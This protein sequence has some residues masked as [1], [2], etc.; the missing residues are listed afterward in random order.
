MS[1]PRRLVLL[2]VLTAALLAACGEA[3]HNAAPALRVEPAVGAPTTA[4]IAHAAARPAV[5]VRPGL[6]A[7]TEVAPPSAAPT[8]AGGH[9]IDAAAD[10]AAEVAAA[11]AERPVDPLIVAGEAADA[12]AARQAEAAA[13]LATARYAAA[14]R[15]D[16]TG[17]AVATAWSEPVYL[18][19]RDVPLILPG[20]PAPLPAFTPRAIDQAKLPSD[21]FAEL[22][23][24]KRLRE[25]K[26]TWL[27]W[28]FGFKFLAIDAPTAKS[29]LAAGTPIFLGPD[30]SRWHRDRAF[31][32]VKDTTTIEAM[33]PQLRQDALDE[34]GRAIRYANIQDRAGVLPAF[35]GTYDVMKLLLLDLIVGDYTYGGQPVRRGMVAA[36]NFY[37]LAAVRREIATWWEDHPSATAGDLRLAI[38]RTLVAKFQDLGR[39]VDWLAEDP[40]L[41]SDSQLVP[42]LRDPRAIEGSDR[43]AHD[44]DVAY[45]RSAIL[46]VARTMPAVLSSALYP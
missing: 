25:A 35:N 37:E 2:P 40:A 12:E 34:A 4:A 31:V 11:L 41:Y 1:K 8:T 3:P 39:R 46:Q 16:A 7:P 36:A 26:K 45:N 5:M 27:P 30:G 9:K 21:A 43:A 18:T 29:R 20:S 13:P 19:P 22:G 23:R 15:T 14:T 38:N 17:A 24:L 6:A 44:A 33:L 28:L 10:E 42:G 32:E